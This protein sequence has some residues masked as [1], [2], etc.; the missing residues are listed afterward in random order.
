M[1]W[2]KVLA[3]GVLLLGYSSALWRYRTNARH[4]TIFNTR[5]TIHLEYEGPDFIEWDVPESCSVKNSNARRTQ[6]FCASPGT[7]NIRPRVKGQPLE[8]E[9]RFLFVDDT[10]NCF[11]W[12]SQSSPEKDKNFQNIKIWTYD[13]ENASP[14]E[15]AGNASEPSMNSMSLSMQF[16]TMGQEPLILS[17][18]TYHTY[19][20]HTTGRGDWEVQVPFTKKNLFMKIRGN[21]V[22]FQDCFIADYMFL[23]SYIK[24][25]FSQDPNYLPMTSRKE[26]I[27]LFDWP[28]CFP[29]TVA[30]VSYWETLFTTDAFDTW[31]KIRIPPNILTE[32]ERKNIEDISL[33]EQGIVILTANSLYLRTTDNFI[34]LDQK[35]GIPPNVI[36][37]ET[38]TY[39]WPEFTPRE[40]LILSEMVVWTE[41]EVYLGYSDLKFKRIFSTVEF[42]ETWKFAITFIPSLSVHRV[43]YTSDPTGVAF[44]LSLKIELTFENL[45]LLVFYDEDTAKW[46][47]QDYALLYPKDKKLNALFMFSALPNFVIWDDETVNYSYQNFSNNGMLMTYHGNSHLPAI[48]KNSRIHQ[49][50]IDYFGNGVIKMY[51][52][53]MLYFKLHITDVALL[54]QWAHES[55]ST[56]I[57]INPTGELFLVNLNYGIAQNS[58]YP[59]MLELFSSTFKEQPV[60]PY[61]LFETSIYFSNIYLDKRDELT[62]WTQVVYMENLGVEAI[63]E[64]YGP[65]VLKEK[66]QVDYEIALGICTKNLTVTFYSGID[67][68][69]VSDYR[70]LQEEHMG[71]VMI[72]LR[73]SQFSKICPFSNKAIHVFVGCFP[74]RHIILKGK[75]LRDN[76]P[77]DK[78]VDYNFSLYGCPFRINVLNQFHP[79]VLLYDGNIFIEEVEANF[80]I[81]E[82]HGRTDFSYTLSMSNAGCVN[83]AQTWKSMMELNKS[84]PMEKVWGPENYRHCFSTASGQ[85]GDLSQP[86]E[87]INTTNENKITWEIHHVGFYVFKIKI[88]DPNYSFCD[89]T[90]TFAIET[91]GIIPGKDPYLMASFLFAILVLISIFLVLSYFQ[92]LRIFRKYIYESTTEP[93]PKRKKRKH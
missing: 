36:G 2:G 34:R 27:I 59:L 41:T 17:A 86:Y 4:Y 6:M 69:A 85:P 32:E 63:V 51:N 26:E 39:C 38:R 88:I 20:P 61:M 62:F 79:V 68:E 42:L 44:M 89:L 15:L 65:K 47:Q 22:A 29:A 83:V 73:P 54:H 74:E 53:I 81:W 60:C 1:F 16:S 67:Y 7:H 75:Y 18:F 58:E 25:N 3:A 48:A 12:Y 11:M 70:K 13:P 28:P 91:F 50:F 46:T 72:Q 33:L 93:K 43:T 71:H 57:L 30:I 77:E 14:S 82:I 5:T 45:L 10:N 21:S 9:E 24:L 52:N 8:A 37:T 78:I 35:F 40:G 56:L 80:I 23:L 19:F 92:Y 66:R 64:L 49:V 55:D 90:A 76:P 31:E 87:I 84:L